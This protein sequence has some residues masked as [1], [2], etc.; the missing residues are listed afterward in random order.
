MSSTGSVRVAELVGQVVDLPKHV[1]AVELFETVEVVEVHECSQSWFGTILQQ[2]SSEFCIG[3][4][5]L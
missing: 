4:V 5:T 2:F 3:I 1:A